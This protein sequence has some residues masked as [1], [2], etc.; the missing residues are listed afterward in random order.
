[1]QQK[2]IAILGAGTMGASTA[3]MLARRRFL[4]EIFDLAS[5]PFSG[6]SRWNEGKIHLGSCITLIHRF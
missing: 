6:A 3:V 2:R 1:V 4:V 5:Q